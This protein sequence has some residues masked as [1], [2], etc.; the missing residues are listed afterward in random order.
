M[1]GGFVEGIKAL[2]YRSQVC[3]GSATLFMNPV[4]GKINL[5]L[6][7]GELLTEDS[8]AARLTDQRFKH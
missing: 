8:I 4:T 1:T 5:M 3:N 2:Q 7:N 6:A